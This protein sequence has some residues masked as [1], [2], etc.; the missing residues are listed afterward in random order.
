[1]E[2]SG[3]IASWEFF[4]HGLL[5]WYGPLYDDPIALLT[6]LRPTFIIKQ[7]QTQFEEL[8]NQTE[9]FIESLMISYFIGGS[10]GGSSVER[11]DVEAMHPPRNY[12]TCSHAGIIRE[13]KEKK[14][15][16]RAR[17]IFS[18]AFVIDG[19]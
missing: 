11:T 15:T 7:Y 18:G 13:L 9:G 12:W 17:N 6:K 5:I 8:P 3:A 4:S 14:T 1:M 19:N 2:K 10:V 16:V